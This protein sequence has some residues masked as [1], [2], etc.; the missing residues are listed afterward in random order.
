MTHSTSFDDFLQAILQHANYTQGA[1]R[2]PSCKARHF[3]KAFHLDTTPPIKVIP[4][5]FIMIKVKIIITECKVEA[6]PFPSQDGV[7]V[8]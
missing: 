3:G 2:A 4:A 6:A 1:A 7:I 5:D 8:D